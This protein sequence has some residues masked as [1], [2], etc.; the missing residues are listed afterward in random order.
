LEQNSEGDDTMFGSNE[1]LL[2][3]LIVIL[4]L[5]VLTISAAANEP[6][7]IPFIQA[8]RLSQSNNNVSEVYIERFA[9]VPEIENAIEKFT[10]DGQLD[11]SV[12]DAAALLTDFITIYD[13]QPVQAGTEV[14]L[15]YD[16][17]NLYIGLKCYTP[18]SGMARDSEEVEILISPTDSEYI[19]RHITIKASGNNSDIANELGT[20]RIPSKRW[21]AF[22]FRGDD[23]WSSEVIIPFAAFGEQA[24]EF[25]QNWRINVIRSRTDFLPVSSWIPIRTAYVDSAKS[26]RIFMKE[27][28]LGNIFFNQ[29][30]S[31]IYRQEKV[32]NLKNIE[33]T[34]RG[35][36]EKSISFN[37]E[38]ESEGSVELIWHSPSGEK[39]KILPTEFSNVHGRIEIIFTHPAPDEKGIYYLEILFA[40]NDDNKLFGTQL[41]FDRESLIRAGASA[42]SELVLRAR[43]VD[44]KTNVNLQKPSE[45]LSK[46]IDLVPDKTGQYWCGSPERPAL[47]PEKLFRWDPSEPDVIT[48]LQ[49]KM[50]FPNEKYPDNRFIEVR[51]PLGEMIKYPYYQAPD[52]MRYYFQPHKWYL[53]REYLV[54]EISRRIRTD[55]SGAAR[56]LYRFAEVYPQ[57]LPMGGRWYI[58]M[59]NEFPNYNPIVEEVGP[60]YAITEPEV[61]VW[62]RWGYIDLLRVGKLADAFGTLRK[63]DIFDKLS[64]EIGEDVEYA[65]EYQMIRPSVEFM[66]TSPITSHNMNP[67]HWEGLAKVGV[68]LQEPDYVHEVVERIRFYM[69]SEFRFD[70]FQREVTI[71]YHRQVIKGLKN[72]MDILSGWSDP[73]G[74]ISPRDGTRYDDLDLIK[75][76]PILEMAFAV[77][78]KLIY[79]N[80]KY[81][82][83]QDTWAYSKTSTVPNNSEPLLMAASGIARLGLGTENNQIQA[84][85]NFT[86]KSGA[87]THRDPLNL[88]LFAK[89]QELLP[90]LGYSL[91]KYRQ[92]AGST[93]GHNTVVVDGKDMSYSDGES[94]GKIEAFAPFDGKVQVIRVDQTNAYIGTVDEY[95]REVWLIQFPKGGG[96]LVDIFRVSGG[97]RHEYTLQGDA[98][99]TSQFESNLS[100]KDYGKY[101]LPPNT[102]VKEPVRDND[103]GYAGGQ[104]Y[105][106]AFVRDVK[107]VAIPDGKYELTL[108]TQ[109]RNKARMNITG[110][111]EP[112]NNTLFIG[113]APSL[114]ATRD[115]NKD[116]NDLA[117]K[118]YMPKYVVRREGNQ[119]RSTF[120]TVMEPYSTPGFFTRLFKGDSGA[121][122]KN[123]KVLT[124]DKYK[125][126]DV[127]IAMTYGDIED[128]ILSSSFPNE[129][130]L[131]DD[132]SFKGKMGFIRLEK[133]KVTNMYLAGGTLLKKGSDELVHSGPIQGE[134]VHVLRKASGDDY[135]G[136]ITDKPVTENVKGDYVVVSHP[137]GFIPEYSLYR[138]TL[139]SSNHGVNTSSGYTHAYRIEDVKDEGEGSL[140]I[141]DMD[142]GFEIKSNGKSFMCYFPF[143]EWDGKHTFQIEGTVI[144]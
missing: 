93:L 143:T 112:G 142:P 104:Y 56:L 94:D 79:P 59:P 99:N 48:C 11:E 7:I 80:G 25:G 27:N 136:F 140:L 96:Y 63:T 30:P 8:E 44:K 15:L 50:K 34:Y 120:I 57:Y 42:L 138:D 122:I 100:L 47:H 39:V 108:I 128:I 61:G 37:M 130:L 20:D 82:P 131:V 9:I 115:M 36:S 3:I 89:G 16:E 88:T 71:S 135:D 38:N 109:E 66:R 55:L 23:F 64:Q 127:A 28:R 40:N 90:D 113:R 119:L 32:C 91:T 1:M 129:T 81:L 62:S 126:G 67:S 29:L 144:K 54:D 103:K 43:E 76:F 132:I 137:K 52:G 86:P 118:Y 134:I 78:K 133:G 41:V 49:S 139:P 4:L 98:N 87:H 24:P 107:N 6:Y 95:M 72:T 46:L 106:Y 58:Y 19:Y 65:I 60:P 2:I 101:L 105:A 102:P 51:N 35:Y 125:E 33:F 17:R 68:A 13:L 92:W 5:F 53:Q 31:N 69:E 45:E 26:G 77:E 74:Y 111:M 121:N 114:R 70:G 123:I 141:L 83:V 124:L 84:Y 117:D 12:W 18:Y 22:T 10:L 85:L 97:S 73:E 21:T 110:F 75:E 116:L 14:K